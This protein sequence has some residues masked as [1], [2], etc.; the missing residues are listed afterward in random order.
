MRHPTT[1]TAGIGKI[2]WGLAAVALVGAPFVVASLWPHAAAVSVP[3]QPVPQPSLPP[4]VPTPQV[5]PQREPTPFPPAASSPQAPMTYEIHRGAVPDELDREAGNP[6]CAMPPASTG[7]KIVLLGSYEGTTSA[8]LSLAGGDQTF[9]ADVVVEPGEEPL[10]VVLTSYSSMIW[11]F[12]GAVGRVRNVVATTLRRSPNGSEGPGGAGVVG[13]DK[14]K[15]AFLG[16]PRCLEHFHEYGSIA[17]AKASGVVTRRLGREPDSIGGI[18][19]MARATIPSM[20]VATSEL[21]RWQSRPTAAIAPDTVVSAG[22]VE[23]MDVLA[24]EEGIRQLVSEGALVPVPGGHNKYRII[25]TFSRFPA[26]LY[27]GHRVD[28]L[29]SKGVEMPGGDVGHSC[30]ISEANGLQIGRGFCMP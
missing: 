9:V 11:K 14:G 17:Q 30:V 15:V 13:L 2:R 16:S 20:K 26:G 10:Y 24:G 21:D 28:F 8:N 4:Q 19:K 29:L 7:Q 23:T 27:C 3:V 1:F 22:P 12:S 18:Y 5:P 6:Y 25:R